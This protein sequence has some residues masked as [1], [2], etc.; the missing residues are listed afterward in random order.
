MNTLN[1]KTHAILYLENYTAS[2][3]STWNL[4]SSEKLEWEKNKNKPLLTH[5]H[6]NVT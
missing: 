3:I 5:F 2:G 6:Q 1:H 4:F